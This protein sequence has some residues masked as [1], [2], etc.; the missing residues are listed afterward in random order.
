[1]T[2]LSHRADLPEPPIG[3]AP[4]AEVAPT[5]EGAVPRTLGLWDQVGLWGNLGVSLL[6]FTGAVFVLSPGGDGAPALAPVAALAAVVVGTLLGTAALSASAVPGA[7]TGA[8]A[9][10]LL[11][12]LFGARLSALPTI[13]NIVQCVGWGTFELVT[14]ATAAHTVAGDV[15]RWV[16]VVVAGAVTTGLA[17]RPLGSVRLLRRY[18]TVLVV[19]ALA[20]L[21]VQL[22]RHPLP[23][24]TRG[25]WHGFWAA[26]DSVVAVAVSFVPLASDYSRHA[27]S[28]RT[29]FW[30]SYLGYGV[31]QVACY[32]LGLVALLTV[33]RSG[34]DIYGA[35]IAVPLGALAFGV[36]ALRELDQSFANVYS[37]AVSV[38]NLRPR[39]DRRVLALAIGAVTTVLALILDVAQY[40]NFLYLLGS[41]F[42]PLFAVLIVDFLARRGVWDTSADAPARPLMLLPWAAGFVVYQLVNPGYL[43]GWSGAWTD[44]RQTLGFTPP[45]WASASL[46]AFAVAALGTAAVVA[47]TRRRAR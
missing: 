5:L 42:V 43:A 24:L 8:P 44:L 31:T 1:M 4:R 10:V 33:A 12:G 27:T 25:S 26:T 16:F 38:Q 11:R 18:V 41:V 35:F 30:G 15:P 19:V 32:G 7:R 28:V 17:L 21:A 39:W 37:T 40:Q 45:G 2:V 46:W 36:L 22:L 14:I 9:M 23:P 29:A 47:G 6:G 13:L 3:D 34:D 20:Y